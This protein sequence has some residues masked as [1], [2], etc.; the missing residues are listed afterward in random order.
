[1]F[2]V[3]RSGLD[4]SLKQLDVL[5]NNIA[6]AK[7]TGYSAQMP[8]FRISMQ[9]RQAFWHQGRSG[10]VRLWIYSQFRSQGPLKQTNQTLVWLSRQG[11]F[12][13]ACRALPVQITAIHVTVFNAG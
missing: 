8:P 3:I 4:A 5:S 11:M 2:S 12:V 7:T 10:M 9:K 6:N 13:Q 1:M